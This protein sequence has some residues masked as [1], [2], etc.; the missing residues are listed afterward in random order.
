MLSYR[1]TNCFDCWF[2]IDLIGCR[3]CLFCSN[4]RNKQF[5]INNEQFTEEEY[6]AKIEK[7]DFGS[8]KKIQEYIQEFNN[9]RANNFVKYANIIRSEDS[10]G[11]DLIECKNVKNFY[12]G[13]RA[14]NSKYSYRAIDIKDSHDL[15]GGNGERVYCSQNI[16]WGSNYMFCSN[17]HRSNNL[18]YC[19]SCYDSHDLFGCVGLRKKEY[20]IFNKQFPSKDEYEKQVAKIIE[21]MQI[22]GEWGEFFP[23]S[24][25]PHAYNETVASNHF[26]HDKKA[27]MDLGGKW[28]DN[29]FALEYTGPF[30]EPKDN[31]ADY[32]NNEIERQKLLT[33]ILRCEVSG[34]PFKIM[35]QELAFYL[36]HGLPIP[37]K[38]FNVRFKERFE[39]RNPYKLY[40]RQCMNEGCQNEFETTYAPDRPEKVYCETCYQKNI[41]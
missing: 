3:D 14:E 28:Q 21:H 24:I 25:S 36:Q 8:Y 13:T 35:P 16:G 30:Y 32:K 10:T 23:L 19:E 26:K 18:L 4:L 7:Y 29:D 38:H 27:I 33:G 34:K 17:V 15:M 41:L 6:R 37:R 31:I 12:N 2:S 5:F 20:C 11:E 40:H 39:I 22:T 1:L 9:L